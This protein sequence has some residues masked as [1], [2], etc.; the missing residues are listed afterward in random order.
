MGWFTVGGAQKKRW[1]WSSVAAWASV[2]VVESL[3][4]DYRARGSI[5]GE[6]GCGDE[7]GMSRSVSMDRWCSCG[8]P[9]NVPVTGIYH[10]RVAA[11]G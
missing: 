2:V 1:W 7:S 4:R 6:T 9:E 8:W 3:K 5:W 11:G 10:R